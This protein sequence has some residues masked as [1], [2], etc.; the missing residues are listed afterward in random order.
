M[1]EPWCGGTARGAWPGRLREWKTLNVD[2]AGPQKHLYRSGKPDS[3]VP[4]N[5]EDWIIFFLYSSINYW[6]QSWERDLLQI[7]RD[8][9]QIS[10]DFPPLSSYTPT[11]SLSL[12]GSWEEGTSLLPQLRWHTAP[13]PTGKLHTPAAY[14]PTPAYSAPGRKKD[15][16]PVGQP[17]PGFVDTRLSLTAESPGS[18][19]YSSG[20]LW[21]GGGGGSVLEHR[22]TCDWQQ[23]WDTE[24]GARVCCLGA[25][26]QSGI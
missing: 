24:M 26:E 19:L 6:Y 20:G 1:G 21:R 15:F 25:G 17:C 4:E 22:I 23:S 2:L 5:P 3:S 7:P 12:S 11:G 16:L 18:R 13:C 10:R 14:A 9:P 8:S